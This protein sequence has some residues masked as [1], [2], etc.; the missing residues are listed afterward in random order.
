MRSA[1]LCLLLLALGLRPQETD[2]EASA[3]R[4]TIVF[5]P[6]AAV[7]GMRLVSATSTLR[8]EG[9]EERPHRLV[10]DYLFPDRAR[11]SLRA[12][13]EE[14]ERG[15]RV[16]RYRAGERCFALAP[17]ELVSE[18]LE[19][20]AA[21]QALLQM[22][23]RRAALLWPDGFAWR[24][25]GDARVATLPG[26]GTLRAE[27]AVDAKDAARPIRFTSAYAD[28]SEC[29]RFEALRWQLAA[30]WPQGFELWLGDRR[31]WTEELTEIVHRGDFLDCYFVPPDRR[32]LG[33]ARLGD[34]ELRHY[35]LPQRAV[36]RVALEP[37]SADLESSRAAALEAAES[38][39]AELESAGENRAVEASLE[40]DAEGRVSALLARID[41]PDELP[42]RFPTKLVADGPALV[43]ELAASGAVDRSVLRSLSESRPVGARSGAFELRWDAAGGVRVLLPLLP[44][45]H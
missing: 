23:L 1:L 33:A 6:R 4:A 35:D 20:R 12:I 26:S 41:V 40:L 5:A 9:L 22:E 19:G 37:P 11:W 39:R 34:S 24:A 14:K 13:G 43:R 15:A 25:E 38:W 32:A 27:F 44:S 16:L 31:V 29:E 8:F 18:E 3:D 28:G 2:T 45:D 17:G 30:R 10:A 21:E 7:A 42:V 36:R